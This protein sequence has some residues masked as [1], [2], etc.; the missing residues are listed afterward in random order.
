M[1]KWMRRVGSGTQNVLNL[2][3]YFRACLNIVTKTPEVLYLL[4]K[5]YLVICSLFS[6]FY[7]QLVYPKI[8][9][10]PSNHRWRIKNAIKHWM[11]VWVFYFNGFSPWTLEKNR[12]INLQN[13]V[14][15]KF[16]S[17]LL[18]QP[19]SLQVVQLGSASCILENR[20][21]Y[22][23]RPKNNRQLWLNVV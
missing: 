4:I 19:S 1:W 18:T 7:H 14:S 3:I 15:M 10:H 22:F 23:K 16:W 9:I 13:N 6:C 17:V 5:V 12:Q 2:N 20:N 11:W 21:L 8:L